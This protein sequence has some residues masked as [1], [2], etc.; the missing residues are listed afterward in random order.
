MNTF[1]VTNRQ[2]SDVQGRWSEINLTR[3]SGDFGSPRRMLP[4]PT[5]LHPLVKLLVCLAGCTSYVEGVLDLNY[6]F[7]NITSS[8]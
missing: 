1:W 5:S 2:R 8:L 3:P 6:E 4:E 7:L